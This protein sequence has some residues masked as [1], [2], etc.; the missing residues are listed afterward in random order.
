MNKNFRYSQ[1]GFTLL[2]TLASIAIISLVIVGPLSV[3][4]SSS[5]YARQTKDI[6][7]ATY[8]AEESIE[9]LQNYYDSLYVYC[10]RN[11]IATDPGELCH[12]VSETTGQTSWRLFKERLGSPSA[13]L[14]SCFGDE[15]ANVGCSFD[16]LDMLGGITPAAPSRYEAS[17]SE[18]PFLVKL[19]TPITVLTKNYIKSSYICSNV[20]SHRVGGVVDDSKSFARSVIIDQLPTFELTKPRYGQY[21]DDLRIT[22]EVDFRGVNGRT[23]TVRVVRFMS[24]RL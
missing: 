21:A 1:K 16:T 8:L 11:P 22:S 3:L 20:P 13:P 5:A 4:S 24:P 23:Q 18:C 12:H 7:V 14:P 2:E 17:S 10:K 15:S 19:E 6:I 9:L